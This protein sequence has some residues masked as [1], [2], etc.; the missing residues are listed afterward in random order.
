[1]QQGAL[2]ESPRVGFVI[3]EFEPNTLRLELCVNGS[4]LLL[5]AVA[6]MANVSS[7]GRL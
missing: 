4:F 5:G 3:I 2:Y 6:L 1:M 7:H